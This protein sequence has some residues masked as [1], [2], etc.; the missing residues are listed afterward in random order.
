[1]SSW[2]YRVIRRESGGSAVYGIHEV[3]YDDS[4]RVETWTEDPVVPLGEVDLKNLQ[5]D[6]SHMFKAMD[7]PVLREFPGP[8]GRDVLI[9]DA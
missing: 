4:G 7:R 3:Y 2:D 5:W 8:D 9:E 1:M 6:L